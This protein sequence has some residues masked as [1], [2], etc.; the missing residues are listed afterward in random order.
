MRRQ[1]RSFVVAV[2][3]VSLCCSLI[4]CKSNGGSW[5]KPNT[6][7][8]H[9]P[10]KKGSDFGE[11]DYG[12][13]AEGNNGIVTPRQGQEPDLNLTTP[14][15]GY[16]GNQV[17]QNTNRSTNANV[18]NSSNPPPGQNPANN[19]NYQTQQANYQN[20]PP[21][22]WNNPGVPQGQPVAQN[23]YYNN[24]PPPQN[25]YPQNY[26]APQT[27]AAT[28]YYGSDPNMNYSAPVGSQPQYDPS[29]GTPQAPYASGYNTYAEE[30]RPSRL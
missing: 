28:P 24:N 7:S 8:F 27:Q 6:Y 12:R 29:Y 21:A 22:N 1:Y 14:S 23:Q 11:D 2:V 19:P 10:F 17:A 3:A 25:P 20:N 18:P 26:Q 9:N 5:Y 16:S 15:G 13:Y 4:G 30:Y